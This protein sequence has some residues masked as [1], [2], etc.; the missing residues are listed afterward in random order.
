MDWTTEETQAD[1]APAKSPLG[2]R[3][4]PDHA[5]M[6]RSWPISSWRVKLRYFAPDRS[7][8]FASSEPITR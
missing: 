2:V 5:V 6:L 3:R 8:A 7:S 4:L 1:P